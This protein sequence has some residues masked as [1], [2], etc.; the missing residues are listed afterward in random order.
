MDEFLI[1][2]IAKLQWIIPK[3]QVSICT[4]CG[5]APIYN[6]QCENLF[7]KK[8][9]CIYINMQI[10]LDIVDWLIDWQIYVWIYILNHDT[11]H[12]FYVNWAKETRSLLKIE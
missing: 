6:I 1:V 5:I 11:L 7:L 3:K 2:E 4:N 12:F 8:F 10:Y 9:L